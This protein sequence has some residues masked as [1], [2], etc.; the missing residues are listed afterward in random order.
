MSSVKGK[1]VLIT[2]ASRGIGE[3]AAR[4]FA[5]QGAKV[6]LTARSG[7]D[8]AR[9]AGEI[10]DAGGT[11]LHLATDVTDIDQ[12]NAAAD[13]AV[14]KFGRL[15]VLIN[16]AGVIE[17]IDRIEDADPAEWNRLIDINVKGVFHGI[18]AALPRMKAVSGGTI[19]TIGSG[20]A[21]SALEGWSAYCTSKAAVHHLNR[22]LYEEEVEHG[23]RAM[24]LSPGTVAT[25]MQVAI[26]DSGVNPVSRMEW[27][28]HIPPEWVGKALVWMCGSDADDWNGSVVSLREPDIRRRVG[29]TG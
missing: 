12:V 4:E 21:T 22:A 3:A 9:I 11:A 23:I 19:I 5:A 26:R 29:L 1:S 18:H 7:G 17:P 14:T 2:G 15:D 8:I 27:S 16:N 10:N 24:V 25:D 6:V 28:S 20:A 13:L